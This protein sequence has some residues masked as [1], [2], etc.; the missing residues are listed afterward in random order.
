MVPRTANGIGDER[1]LGE[2]TMVMR[3]LR[4]DCKQGSTAAGEQNRLASDL[5]RDHGA[6][7]EIRDRYPFAKVGS[8]E[9][10]VFVAHDCLLPPAEIAA[11]NLNAAG[12][13]S[14]HDIGISA[15]LRRFGVAA[16][17]TRLDAEPC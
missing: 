5:S 13:Q 3:A 8:G 15:A 7:G 10:W 2:R 6:L 17:T 1:P 12:G 16:P 11:V 4:P 9:L 14:A